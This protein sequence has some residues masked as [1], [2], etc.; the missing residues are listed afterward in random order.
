MAVKESAFTFSI[1]GFDSLPNHYRPVLPSTVE[2]NP[3]PRSLAETRWRLNIPNGLKAPHVTAWAKASTA[4]AG[5]GNLPNITQPCK[6][7]TSN[8][9]LPLPHSVGLWHHACFRWLERFI[10]IVLYGRFDSVLPHPAG[11]G[12]SGNRDHFYNRRCSGLLEEGT[13]AHQLPRIQATSN[14][15]SSN[16]A[17]PGA[18]CYRFRK[19]WCH[20]SLQSAQPVSSLN[21]LN[22]GSS[23]CTLASCLLF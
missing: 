15:V 4:N 11:H 3:V 17:F 5:P 13:S 8:M 7:A 9:H 22:S 6:G 23:P 16:C 21:N 14:D 12:F 10:L 1:S 20:S 18:R 19:R 2:N